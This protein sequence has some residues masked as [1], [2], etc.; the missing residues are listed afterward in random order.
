MKNKAKYVLPFLLLTRLAG[1][2]KTS[3]GKPSNKLSEA[4]SSTPSATAKPTVKKKAK[5][6]KER[7]GSY[8]K[9]LFFEETEY[10]YIDKKYTAY[11][12]EGTATKDKTVS[13]VQ[14]EGTSYDDPNSPAVPEKESVKNRQ[15]R[16]GLPY[17]DTYC[18][19]VEDGIK[20]DNTYS[21]TQPEKITDF[22][23]YGNP[24]ANREVDDFEKNF[25]ESTDN[26]ACYSRENI[27]TEAKWS[28]KYFF[29]LDHSEMA[30][31]SFIIYV[32]TDSIVSFKLNR[33]SAKENSTDTYTYVGK[34]ISTDETT[35]KDKFTSAITGTPDADLDAALTK[36]NTAT[37]FKERLE[38]TRSA[39]GADVQDVTIS[40]D[41]YVTPDLR[42]LVSGRE[43]GKEDEEVEYA[44]RPSPDKYYALVEYPDKGYY[45]NGLEQE[46][47][48]KT[49]SP[50]CFDKKGEKTYS[51]KSSDGVKIKATFSDYSFT[52]EA[53]GAD[54]ADAER[55][56]TSSFPSLTDLTIT[57]D[58]D[59]IS[60][61]GTSN[62]KQDGK[63]VTFKVKSIY[64]DFNSLTSDIDTKDK[65]KL[66]KTCEDLKW[67]DRLKGS[68]NYSKLL[69]QVK[70]NLDAIPT[71]GKT[72]AK[73]SVGS[74]KEYFG[75]DGDT[76]ETGDSSS[77]ADKDS[78]IYFIG[79]PTGA[80][81]YYT[82]TDALHRRHIINYESIRKKAGYTTTRSERWDSLIA[83]KGTQTVSVGFD[84][85]HNVDLRVVIIQ[86]SA[87]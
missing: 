53:T 21:Y 85:T 15:R 30:I 59:S 34:F 82:G 58:Q 11:A 40:R 63:M 60:F 8:S 65:T 49:V 32:T 24:F 2:D 47:D 13:F 44:Y 61:E 26:L 9:S 45:C 75:K 62:L 67:S 86:D 77:S 20:L 64:T 69:E 72:L 25:K 84:N 6:T 54:E 79:M 73:A 56:G 31:D 81:N 19:G 39:P 55:P 78:D 27:S 48:I 37:S 35:F 16:K 80:T 41:N 28:L 5:L 10:E 14:Y 4:V 38:F 18:L 71:P 12:I 66:H 1:C 83:T 36:L 87:E 50:L 43:V 29:A 42:K 51:R 33:V 76:G 23:Y 52:F 22:K 70:G 7:L 17:N 74:L 3:A 46:R 57:F 68:D